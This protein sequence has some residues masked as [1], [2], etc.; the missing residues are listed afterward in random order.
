MVKQSSKK[1][2]V[3]LII[4]YFYVLL[5]LFTLFTVASYTWFSLSKTP[6]VS[7]MQMFINAQTGLEI[8]VTPDAEEWGLQLDFREISDTTSPLRPVTWS[9]SNQRFYAAVYG[10][11]GRMR[12]KWEPLTD[13]RHANKN[14]ID[15]YYIKST[16]YARS[17]QAVDVKLSPAVEVDEGIK[18]SGTYLIGY[19]EWDSE[20][21]VH[22][23]GGNGAECA[24]RIGI[25]ITPVN[26][27]GIPTGET[28]EFYIY[29]PNSDMHIN[30]TAGYVETP[31]IDG[32]ASLVDKDHLILQS[33]STWTEADPVQREVVIHDLGEFS[34]DTALFKLE[35]GEMVKIDLYVWLEGQDVDCSNEINRARIM[36]NIQ[37]ATDVGGQ[38]GLHPIN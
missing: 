12:N 5:V 8:S 13:A 20:E 33:A 37:F 28:S 22:Y 29:E 35:A 19:P 36:A 16:F 17:G 31:S 27:S 1:K 25:R 38:S 23:N 30:G 4:I 3:K 34:T 6:R 24:M 9:N 15:G 18:G 2:K 11:D 21:V 10:Y 7:D 26:T 14:T 32:T